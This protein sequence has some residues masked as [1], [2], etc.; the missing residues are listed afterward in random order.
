MTE[1]KI[2]KSLALIRQA[3]AEYGPDVAFACSFGAE[4]VVLL[5]LISRAG[6]SIA[7]ITLDTGRLPQE[8]YDV[9]DACRKRYSMPI[10]VYFPDA[11]EVE[12]MVREHGLNLFRDSVELRKRCCEIRKIHPLRRA[13]AGRKA[14]MTGVRRDQ[15]DSRQQMAAVEDD[16]HFGIRKFNPLI[17]WSEAEVWAYIREHDV[18]YNA[19]HDR[20]YPSIGCAPCSRAIAVGEDPRA[21]RWWWEQED[22]VAECGLHASP[23]KKR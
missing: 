21:G 18:P 16:A 3:V 17:E 6:R 12:A 2:E 11:A 7:V 5:D 10:E 22:G 20:H 23:L 1:S 13:L 15:A 9:M 19:L 8:T 14:W 4:D